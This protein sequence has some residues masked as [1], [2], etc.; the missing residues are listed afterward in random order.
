MMIKE[1]GSH[2]EVIQQL[3]IGQELELQT[4][5]QVIKYFLNGMMLLKVGQ[6]K[7]MME[8]R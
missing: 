3:V 2:L 8:L 5:T 1:L 6:V 7:L 4:Q